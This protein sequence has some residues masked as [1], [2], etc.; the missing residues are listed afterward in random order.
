MIDCHCHLVYPG[1]DEIKEKVIENA[2]KA[3]TAIITCGYPKDWQKNLELVKKHEG[4]IFLTLG[5]HPIDIVKMSD[6]EVDKYL[7]VIRSHASEIVGIGEVGLD[8]HW[9]PEEK[10][11]E[12]FRKIFVK[13]LDLAKEVDL[14]VILHLRKAEE[15]GYRIVK[16]NK[17]KKV[18]FH[19]Y[20]GNITLAKKIIESGYYISLATNVNRSKNSKTIARKFPLNKLLTETDS[21][22]LSQEKDKPNVPQ[23]V[24]LVVEVIARE[25]KI[26][27]EEVD[28][29]MTKNAI[30]F[31]N[32]NI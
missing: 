27:F 9:Y 18:N 23:N 4:F 32:L 17:M 3:M 5:L 22:F 16:E 11:N 6:E 14:P 12:R 1:L 7:G 30:R 10:L 8:R 20:A 2:K 31:F 19:C 13:C 25:R 21:P 29:Q 24:R 26:S 28:K 15:D